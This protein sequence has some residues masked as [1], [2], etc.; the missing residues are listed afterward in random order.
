MG[1]TMC[2]Q[3]MLFGS[4]RTLSECK[5]ALD[6]PI[7]APAQDQEE[8]H[9]RGLEHGPREM[10][11]VTVHVYGSGGARPKHAALL[12]TDIMK[13]VASSTQIDSDDLCEHGQAL[14]K[15]SSL[16]GRAARRYSIPGTDCDR[17]LLG[18][19]RRT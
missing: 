1:L 14:A 3:G 9:H 8:E 16:V 10:R 19:L 4:L 15:H 5:Q 18:H 12:A 11:A 2:H 17:I 6:I 13:R 7:M